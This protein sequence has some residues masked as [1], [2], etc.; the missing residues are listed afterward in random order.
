MPITK[1]ELLEELK[2]RI[3]STNPAMA[4]ALAPEAAVEDSIT[5]TNRYRRYLKLYQQV[6]EGSEDDPVIAEA[7]AELGLR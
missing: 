2:V 1:G 7:A 4:Q 3:V 6:T 5:R